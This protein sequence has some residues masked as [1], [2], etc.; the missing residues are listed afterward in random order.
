M[1]A[2]LFLTSGTRR[3][4]W[5]RIMRKRR[6]DAGIR[7]PTRVVIST[8]GIS[9]DIDELEDDARLEDG[10]SEEDDDEEEDGDSG[11]LVM[12][13]Q[14]STMPQATLILCDIR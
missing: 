8:E 11:L 14:C 5:Q 3:R 6:S 12:H 9:L 10:P 13:S 7:R 2:Q 1:A 4:G